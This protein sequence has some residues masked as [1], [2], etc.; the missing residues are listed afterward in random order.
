MPVITGLALFLMIGSIVVPLSDSTIRDASKSIEP[1]VYQIGPANP[2]IPWNNP[3]S[4]GAL[5]FLSSIFISQFGRGIIA[6]KYG[7]KI[8]SWGVN[9]IL[10]LIPM[11]FSLNLNKEEVARLPLKR[12][13]AVL[14]V[15]PLSN[16]VLAG[17]SLF[18]LLLITSTLVVIDPLDPI[19]YGLVITKVNPGSLAETAGLVNGDIIQQIQDKVVKNPLELNKNLNDS[20]GKSVTIDIIDTNMSNQKY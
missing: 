16:F 13:S 12:K 3:L 19:L 18:F 5:A 11:N 9:T 17:I 6:R 1:E 14:T 8:E 20:L 10:G 7:I 4:I 15:D 2:Y